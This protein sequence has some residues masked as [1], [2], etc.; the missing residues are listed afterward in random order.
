MSPL[1]L[2]FSAFLISAAL[3]L[4]LELLDRRL[5]GV[6][7]VVIGIALFVVGIVLAGFYPF[8]LDANIPETATRIVFGA[9]WTCGDVGLLY[10]I[11]VIRPR[12]GRPSKRAD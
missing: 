9:A 7:P 1:D 10:L 3:T 6:G 5:V 12:E 4:V 11:N 8:E 2:A